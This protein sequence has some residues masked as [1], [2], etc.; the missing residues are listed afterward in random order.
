MKLDRTI[1]IE[2]SLND[3]WGRL[4]TAGKSAEFLATSFADYAALCVALEH[5]AQFI[6]TCVPAFPE[7]SFRGIWLDRFIVIPSPEVEVGVVIPFVS[8]KRLP[9]ALEAL[10]EHPGVVRFEEIP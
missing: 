2:E 3:I 10:A 8:K 7:V 6:D 5:R 4:G 1:S 9:T